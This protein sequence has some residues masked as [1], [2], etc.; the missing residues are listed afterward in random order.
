MPAKVL[1]FVLGLAMLGLGFYFGSRGPEED[2]GRDHL[3]QLTKENT[4]LREEVERLRTQLEAST[5]STPEL[6]SGP[7]QSFWM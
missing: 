2:G 6:G 3:E 1:T 7:G 4:R 5:P